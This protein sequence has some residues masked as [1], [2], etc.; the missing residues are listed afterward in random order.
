[1]V[2]TELR[3]RFLRDVKTVTAPE[4]LVTIATLPS[5]GTEVAVNSSKLASKIE[6]ITHA[7]D[8]DFRLKSNP[9]VQIVGYVLA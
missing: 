8:D 3:K 6:Y 7:Y 9:L 2:G 5:G 4:H 1:M